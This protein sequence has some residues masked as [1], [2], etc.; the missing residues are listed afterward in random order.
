VAIDTS[1]NAASS[2]VVIATR[3]RM[4]YSHSSLFW[5]GIALQHYKINTG[6]WQVPGV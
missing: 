1:V 5:A 4:I 3:A 6:K 2:I